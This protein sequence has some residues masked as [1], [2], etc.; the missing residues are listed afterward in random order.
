MERPCRPPDMSNF[1]CLPGR[2]GGTPIGVR[3]KA[4]SHESRRQNA[5]NS[6]WNSPNRGVSCRNGQLTGAPS[7]VKAGL[8]RFY[9]G[10]TG[11]HSA[12]GF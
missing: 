4:M 7:A 12:L 3:S 2:A 6:G 8:I 10:V 9:R 5:E 11:L 1:C